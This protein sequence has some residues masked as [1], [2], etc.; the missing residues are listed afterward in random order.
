MLNLLHV[1]KEADY[2]IFAANRVVGSK[3]HD[4]PVGKA[5]VG[6][7]VAG[8]GKGKVKLLICDRAFL[9]AAIISRFKACYG[10]DTLMPLKKNMDAVSDAKGL[11]K[12]E[13][14]PWKKIDKA[15]YCYMAKKIRSY[16]GVSVDLNVIL[17]RSEQKSGR[18]RLWSLV[19]A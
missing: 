17:L 4:K 15:T 2:F 16:Q 5:L 7:Y 3:S 12:L 14:V 11:L 6:E 18:V 1:S 8:V 10:I 9:D 13:K 19:T